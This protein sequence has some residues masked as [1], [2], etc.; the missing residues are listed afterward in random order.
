MPLGS[1]SN[2]KYYQIIS[3]DGQ[4]LLVSF[5]VLVGNNQ[6]G[7]IGLKKIFERWKSKRMKPEAGLK[8]MF[9]GILQS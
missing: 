7:L 5:V 6:M 4:G 2:Y 1:K 8:A 9:V 3:P